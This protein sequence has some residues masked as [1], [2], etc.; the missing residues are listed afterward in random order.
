MTTSANKVFYNTTG[1]NPTAT[2]AGDLYI[3][4]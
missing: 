1:T 2:A 4:Y 3:H